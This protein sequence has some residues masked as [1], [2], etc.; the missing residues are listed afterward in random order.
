MEEGGLEDCFSGGIDRKLDGAGAMA[1]V[2]LQPI[3]K[4]EGGVTSLGRMRKNDGERADRGYWSARSARPRRRR[5]SANF[6]PTSPN[7]SNKISCPIIYP[8]HASRFF[9]RPKPRYRSTVVRMAYYSTIG[10]EVMAVVSQGGE[11]GEIRQLCLLACASSVIPVR[12]AL[13]TQPLGFPSW[14]RNEA[15]DDT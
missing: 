11:G 3:R 13:Q 2:D 1:E 10:H 4:T 8:T 6:S 7:F 12:Y 14:G 5:I 9:L 15:D